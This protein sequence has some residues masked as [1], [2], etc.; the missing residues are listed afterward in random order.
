MTNML[1]QNVLNQNVLNQNV[2]NQNVLFR[3]IIEDKNQYEL[4]VCVCIHQGK[5]MV[6]WFVKN[7]QKYIKNFI[8]V[9]HYNSDEPIN[10]NELPEN[11]WITRKRI[12]TCRMTRRLFMGWLEAMSFGNKN[13]NFINYLILSSGSGLITNIPEIKTPCVYQKTYEL[14]LNPT[15]KLLHSEQISVKYLENIYPFMQSQTQNV[16]GAFKH[17]DNDTVF[18]NSVKKR[19]FKYIKTNQVSGNLF[20]KEVGEWLIEDYYDI[21]DGNDY[22]MEEVY[23]ST[24]AYNWAL[25]N[26]KEPRYSCIL[27]DWDNYFRQ[28]TPEYIHNVK[29]YG[30]YGICK[31]DDNPESYIRKFINM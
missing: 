20:P 22:Q 5:N 13:F 17:V 28:I 3:N 4:C 21:F 15:K 6:N 14:L 12:N 29:K 10:E 23:F 1:N 25:L 24:Y 18:T 30:C 8:C 19:N 2:L 31:I 9:I 16:W 7:L 11:F 27:I 26:N